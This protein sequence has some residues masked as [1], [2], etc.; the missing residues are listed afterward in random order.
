MKH[1]TST[2]KKQFAG[3]KQL[4]L[5]S[6]KEQEDFL[7]H[8]PTNPNWYLQFWMLAAD[9]RENDQK[10]ETSDC[11]V[12]VL[13]WL[14]ELDV[15]VDLRFHTGDQRLFDL[16]HGIGIILRTGCDHIASLFLAFLH[17]SI[18]PIL[19]LGD[20]LYNTICDKPTKKTK[21]R[22]GFVHSNDCS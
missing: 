21:M 1:P 4:V 20:L 3:E 6:W 11:D 8:E 9:T 12:P 5:I 16:G 14:E 10:R 13:H 19:E 7:D 18:Q 22:R 15:F 17:V 2:S